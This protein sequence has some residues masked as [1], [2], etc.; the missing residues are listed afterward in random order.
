[1]NELYVL[2]RTLLV[3]ALLSLV[4]CDPGMSVRQINSFVESKNR[5][6]TAVP[7]LSVDVK[8]THQLIGERWYDPQI[9]ATNSSDIPITITSVE[10]I[11]GTATFQNRPQAAKDYPV[12]LPAHRAAPLNVDFRFSDDL[13]VHKVF[14]RPAELRIH[15]STERGSGLAHI[16]V[17]RGNLNAM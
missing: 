16:T 4:A 11:A 3:L 10:L 9:I 5:G 15:Y 14:R 8:T 7:K 1:M 12:T 6:V 17:A 13:D 2:G